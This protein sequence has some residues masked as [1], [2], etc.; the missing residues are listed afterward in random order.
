MAHEQH[1]LPRSIAGERPQHGGLVQGIQV[2]RGL[3]KQ[4]EGGVVQEHAREA[5][6]LALAARKRVAEFPHLGIET[7]R[8]PANEVG[9]GGLLARGHDF[10]IAR[11]RFREDKVVANGA[12]EQ[13]RFLRHETLHLA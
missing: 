6:P 10:L 12:R 7:R 4:H 1:R 8:K 11:A 9:D 2:A 3:I 5:Q 13:V